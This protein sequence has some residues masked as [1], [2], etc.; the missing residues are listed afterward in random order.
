M[1]IMDQPLRAPK[2]L[3]LVVDDEELIRAYLAE[4]LEDE[5]FDVLEADDGR[6]ALKIVREHPHLDLIVT[7]IVMPDI[8]G[9][10]FLI[11]TRR[12]GI[13]LGSAPKILAISG[14]G[15][16]ASAT[17]YL[18]AAAHLGADLILAKPFTGST[19]RAALNTLGLIRPT[20]PDASP[21]HTHSQ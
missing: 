5:D 1:F 18:D 15:S 20:N 7:D 14:G 3:A 10:A 9:I 12:A 17:L 19:F 6:A 21:E 4:M 11:A 16:Y 8:D 2:R 13:A